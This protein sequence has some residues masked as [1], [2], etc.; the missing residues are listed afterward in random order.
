VP[1]DTHTFANATEKTVLV[2]V[3][4]SNNVTQAFVMNPT[5]SVSVPAGTLPGHYRGTLTISS[6]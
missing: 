4:P 3:D 1:G 5:M 6:L 2:T